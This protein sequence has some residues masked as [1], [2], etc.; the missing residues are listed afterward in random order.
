MTNTNLITTKVTTVAVLSDS[1]QPEL[2]SLLSTK[3]IDWTG[4]M[5]G[6]S[7]DVSMPVPLITRKSRMYGLILIAIRDLEMSL[8][9]ARPREII[10][11]LGQLRLHYAIASMREEEL[12]VLLKDYVKDLA[13]Y[14]KDILEQACIEY[15][16]KGANIFF[17][18]IGLLIDYM[19]LYWYP[20]KGKLR[21]LKKLLEVSNKAEEELQRKL[22]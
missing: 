14:P 17:P 1:L 15:R 6:M 3:G 9:P 20:R 12:A 11:L 8:R 7:T 4:M 5:L 22:K 10:E 16:K 18:K 19:D 13:P 2:E 21:R